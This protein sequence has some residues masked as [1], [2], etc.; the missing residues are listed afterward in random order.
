[1]ENY[2]TV[3]KKL[4]DVTAWIEKQDHKDEVITKLTA[5]RCLEVFGIFPYEEEFSVKSTKV[6]E[7][8]IT[9]P[10]C[11][12]K[13]NEGT[14]LL[15]EMKRL[16]ATTKKESEEESDISGCSEEE[17]EEEGDES[18]P[19]KFTKIPEVSSE[20]VEAQINAHLKGA[21]KE[22][23]V[24][25]LTGFLNTLVEYDEKPTT[26]AFMHRCYLT[27]AKKQHRTN[28]KS[29]V[30][31]SA[32]IFAQVLR[33]IIGDYELKEGNERSKGWALGVPK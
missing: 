27:Y 1:M 18:E 15:G 20:A 33:G 30:I 7:K 9:R 4:Q 13:R 22:L 28:A 17:G 19:N 29:N 31:Q 32:K 21:R 11:E 6:I 25:I 3:V 26:S 14:K 23:M 12:G 16:K 8:F 5:Q 10:A 24:T 2:T